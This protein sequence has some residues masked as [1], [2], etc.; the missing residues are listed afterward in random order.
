MG[1][2]PASLVV[3][4]ATDPNGAVLELANGEPS[5]IY[6]VVPVDGTLRIARGVV[7]NFYQFTMPLDKRLTDTEWGHMIGTVPTEGADGYPEYHK[8][9]DI[10]EKPDWTM[11]Y[12]AK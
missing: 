7:F 9:D 10:P 6:A 5:V 2:H 11:S 3:D 12:R 1:E 8:S 4:I